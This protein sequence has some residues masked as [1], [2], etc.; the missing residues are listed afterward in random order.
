[1]GWRWN[2][3]SLDFYQSHMFPTITLCHQTLIGVSNCPPSREG[4]CSFLAKRKV[5][6]WV[7]LTLIHCPLLAFYLGWECGR[8]WAGGRRNGKASLS[9]KWEFPFT[10]FYCLWELWVWRPDHEAISC[11]SLKPGDGGWSPSHRIFVSGEL[12]S[13]K[14]R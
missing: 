6:V 9:L 4:F 11:L 1:M 3:F 10:F 2:I 7:S 5:C 13:S 12:P 14:R 8:L